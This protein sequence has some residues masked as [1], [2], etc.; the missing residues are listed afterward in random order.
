MLDMHPKGWPVEEDYDLSWKDRRAYVAIKVGAI[1]TCS[2][3][4]EI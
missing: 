2:A 3:T 1:V 4:S